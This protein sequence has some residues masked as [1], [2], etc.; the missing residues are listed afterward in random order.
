MHALV[1]NLVTVLIQ[2]VLDI[3]SDSQV[4]S[5]SDKLLTFEQL[6]VNLLSNGA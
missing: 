3:S 1:G 2:S 6:H 4:I 5:L